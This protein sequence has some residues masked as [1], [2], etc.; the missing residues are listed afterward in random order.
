MPSSC[1][2][3]DFDGVI[4]DTETLHL[5]AYN[6]AFTT[7]ADTLGQKLEISSEAYFSRYIVYGNR[8]GFYH[9]LNDTLAPAGLVPNAPIID[10][11]SQT[12]EQF[13][14]ESLHHF[15][16]PLPG[17]RTLLQW[18]QDHHVPRAICSGARRKEIE[19]L[20]QAFGVADY[21]EFMVTIEDVRFGKP[22]PEG[23]NL[24]FQKLYEKY[25]AALDK[26]QSLVVEDSAGGCSAAKA[27]GI[28]VLGVAINLP[29]EKLKKCATH[30]IPDLSHVDYAAL[31]QW[32]GLKK[33]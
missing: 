19:H 6:H 1:V 28:P 30:A 25:D 12:K 33:A 15:A 4:A 26:K 14:E 17:V 13:F 21:F 24:A 5:Q 22:D 20:L 32:L 16:E 10:L 2:I 31:S 27:A 23:Y 9:M 7:H 11:L 18:L 8:E 29:L 3:F